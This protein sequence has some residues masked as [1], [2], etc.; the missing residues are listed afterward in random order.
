MLTEQWRTATRSQ[1]TNCVEVRRSG[2]LV[3]VRDSKDR[4]GGT[5][6]FTAAAWEAFVAGA[7]QGEFDLT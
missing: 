5:L 7:K 4:D 2:G 3:E 6:G 1:D